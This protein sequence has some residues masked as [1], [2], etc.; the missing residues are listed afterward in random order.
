[1]LGF[2]AGFAS[3]LW[4]YL[5]AAAAALAGLLAFGASSRARGRAAAGA[6]RAARDH[7]ARDRQLDAALDRA[8]G[9]DDL[10]RRLRDRARD[11]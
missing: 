5:A 2:L 4:G 11:L 9:R 8:D 3:G 7:D 10:A 6:E 1:M